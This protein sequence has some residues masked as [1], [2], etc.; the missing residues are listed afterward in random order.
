M[1]TPSDGVPSYVPPAYVEWVK[2]AAAATGLSVGVVAAQIEL[3]SGFN[4]KATSPTGAQGIAQF[5]PGTWKSY[6][7]GSAYDPNNALPAYIGLM[8][9]LLKQFGGDVSK[10]LAAYNAGPG[11]IAAGAGYARRILGNA[12]KGG[13][14]VGPGTGTAP[15]GA[16]GGTAPAAPSASVS[17][18]AGAVE[19]ELG[20]MSPGTGLGGFL[21][22]LISTPSTIWT[23][24]I[25]PVLA[26]VPHVFA[27]A[28]DL[29]KALEWLINPVS[30]VRIGAAIVGSVLLFLGIH[31]ITAAA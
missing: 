21:G 14:T 13:T 4:P 3:E 9:D 17:S 2:Q 25:S 16:G 31:Q 26:L 29:L 18:I 20:A 15:G 22:G 19:A 10:A 27:I 24:L 5:E 1:A 28:T 11:N 30:W 8:K 7:H 23:D 6:G 12:G